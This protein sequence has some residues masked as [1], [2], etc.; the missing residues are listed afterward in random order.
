MKTMKY[1]TAVLASIILFLA[2]TCCNNFFHELIPPDDNHISEFTVEGQIGDSDINND[3]N[4]INI[5]WNSK[6][7]VADKQFVSGVS[8]ADRAVLLPV[9]PEYIQAAFPSIEDYDDLIKTIEEKPAESLTS[10]VSELIRKN[11]DFNVPALDEPID[12]SRPVTLLVISG[13][14]SVRRYTVNIV[15]YITFEANG[16]TGIGVQGVIYGTAISKP[17]NPFRQGYTFGGWYSDNNT[18]DRPWNFDDVI[19]E[20]VDLYAKWTP[21]TYTVR[22]DKN[23]ADAEGAMEDSVHTYDIGKALNPNMFTR[24]NYA[25]GTWNTAPDGSGMSYADGHTVRNLSAT[26][27]AVVT[28]YVRWAPEKHTVTFESNNGE[29][30]FTQIVYHDEIIDNL[31]NPSR[32]GYAFGGWFRDNGTFTNRWTYYDTVT[33]DITLYA[34]WIPVYTVTFISNGGSSVP[35]QSVP[36]GETAFRPSDPSKPNNAFD[37]WYRDNDTFNNSWNFYDPVTSNITLYAKWIPAYTVTFNSNGGSSVPDQ[38]VPSGGKAFRPSDPSRPGY[39]FKGWFRD[40]NTFNNQW[41]FNNLVTEDINLYASWEQ[42][43]TKYTVTYYPDDG[44]PAPV[45]RTDVLHG[46]VIDHPAPMTKTGYTFDGWYT[47]SAKTTPASFPITVTSNITLYAKWESVPV[48][49]KYTVTYYPDGG[50]PAPANRTDVL[51]GTVIDHPAP[52]TKTGYTFD[53]WYTNSAKTT[54]ASFPITVT[55]NITLYAKWVSEPIEPPP[56][57]PSYT[58]TFDSNGGSSVSSKE[59]TSGGKVSRPSNPIRTGYTFDGWYIDNGTFNNRWNF[60]TDTVNGPIT[61]Y[62]NWVPEPTSPTTYTV[63]FDSH[64][65]TLVPDQEIVHGGKVTKPTDN[66]TNSGYV[67]L[68]WFYA[69]Y[70]WNFITDS[71]TRNITLEAM[72]RK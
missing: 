4:I 20:G 41:N 8:L 31:P 16:G 13:Q 27:G 14:G 22:Y 7:R 63:T 28:L 23:A 42:V 56:V 50:S 54:P 47:N 37:G 10:F 32:P 65:G 64:G 2:L 36:S 46:T 38:S 29:P 68:G 71:V 62:A 35:A 60:D 11:R 43:S 40:N 39:A 24:E 44:S 34:K 48:S 53:G 69:G 6:M 25:F 33:G 1:S 66:P 57:D 30:V 59:V 5:P 17:G 45:N 49:P 67:F 58:V 19:T 18:F 52:M 51:H 26:D 55:S 12:F 15:I 21:V 70:E 9:T 72:W 3:F 61:L